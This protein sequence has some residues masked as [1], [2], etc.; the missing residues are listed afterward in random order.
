MDN[1]KTLIIQ[2]ILLFI[3]LCCLGW[4]IYVWIEK[5]Q[6]YDK[7]LVQC[8]QEKPCM[9]PAQL[10]LIIRY[11]ENVITIFNKFLE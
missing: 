9:N 4:M 5:K 3:Q 6:K 8:A 1:R 11:L 2:S 10:G 7:I